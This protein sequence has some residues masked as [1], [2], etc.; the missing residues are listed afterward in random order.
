MISINC[1]PQELMIFN[2]VV[3]WSSSRPPYFILQFS[4]L[5]K[6]LEALWSA[7]LH[8]HCLDSTADTLLDYNNRFLG[9]QSY[10]T[11]GL[12]RA[13]PLLSLIA[14]RGGVGRG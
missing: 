12:A 7:H 2:Q 14:C 11:H 4:K 8:D 5:L 3:P 6:K 13:G 9:S 10:W 1:F